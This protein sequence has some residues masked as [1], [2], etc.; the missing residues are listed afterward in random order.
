MQL[1]QV[2]HGKLNRQNRNKMSEDRQ[3]KLTANHQQF[4]N[5]IKQLIGQNET[6]FTDPNN[7][8]RKQQLII[9]SFSPFF[10]CLQIDYSQTKWR[11]TSHKTSFRDD[12]N[13]K[14]DE[15]DEYFA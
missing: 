5:R 9:I 6:R 4:N 8:K 12:T 10:F 2:H 3:R 7:T 15:D 11:V 14:K 1:T 13:K